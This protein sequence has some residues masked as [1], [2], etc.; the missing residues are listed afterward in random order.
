M[1]RW[2]LISD[3]YINEIFS[4]PINRYE[5]YTKD[6]NISPLSVESLE[7]FE[8]ASRKILV[9]PLYMN[10]HF[11]LL[12]S[13]ISDLFNSSSCIIKD[14]ICALL[15][16]GRI[17]H[18]QISW[19]FDNLAVLVFTDDQM[20]IVSVTLRKMVYIISEIF[21][22]T[23]RS[24]LLHNCP[25]K[26]ISD[27]D[28]EI[29]ACYFGLINCFL[30]TEIGFLFC[31]P[32]HGSLSDT[33]LYLLIPSFLIINQPILLKKFSREFIHTIFI[34][35]E[36]YPCLLIETGIKISESFLL[37]QPNVLFQHL[38]PDMLLL[39]EELIPRVPHLGLQIIREFILKLQPNNNASLVRILGPV[40]SIFALNGD[41]H[42]EEILHL[43][44]PLMDADCYLVRNLGLSTLTDILGLKCSRNSKSTNSYIFDLNY[45]L[46]DNL[47][48]HILDLNAFVRTRC[49]SLITSLWE[50]DSIPLNKQSYFL[51][52]LVGRIFDTSVLVRKQTFFALTSILQK[53]PFNS[54]VLNFQ[55][56]HLT[57]EREL[58]ILQS[59][60]SNF[61]D[62]FFQ[63]EIIDSVLNADIEDFLQ[64]NDD[65]SII[66]C[67]PQEEKCLYDKLISEVSIGYVGDCIATFDWFKRYKPKHFVFQNSSVDVTPVI[68]GLSIHDLLTLSTIIRN[69]K[70]L[71]CCKENI[72]QRELQIQKVNFL[73]S[74][75]GFIDLLY[76]CLPNALKTLQ[77]N[78]SSD[79]LSSLLFLIEYIKY[80]LPDY[81]TCINPIMSLIWSHHVAHRE[82]AIKTFIEYFDLSFNNGYSI[83]SQ[84][85]PMIQSVSD[86][87][88]SNISYMEYYSIER[89]LSSLAQQR[90]FPSDLFS[91]LLQFST[92]SHNFVCS[93]F[94]ANILM[95][96]CMIAR[97]FDL[98]LHDDFELIASTCFTKNLMNLEVAR[99]GCSA[100]NIMGTRQNLS[101][102]QFP[103]L[104]ISHPI[105]KS[106]QLLI[107]SKLCDPE[108]DWSS[109]MFDSLLL[110]LKLS[111]AP[112][113]FFKNCISNCTTIINIIFDERR[114]LVAISRVFMLIGRVAQ[115]FILLMENKFSAPDY[116]SFYSSSN[117]PTNYANELNHVN[118]DQSYSFF[119]SDPD[120]NTDGIGSK[121]IFSRYT[122]L[123]THV[124]QNSIYVDFSKIFKHKSNILISFVLQLQCSAIFALSQLMMLSIQFCEISIGLIVSLMTKHNCQYIRKSCIFVI[125]DLIMR[126]PNTLQPWIPYV[127]RILRDSSALVRKQALLVLSHLILIDIVKI[128]GFIAEIA[129][130]IED[131]NS[132]I[133]EIAMSFFSSISKDGNRLY[134]AL[135]DII[136]HILDQNNNQ[137]EVCSIKNILHFIFSYIKKEK[138]VDKLIEKL[139]NRFKSAQNNKQREL[140][141]F[142]IS[143]LPHSERTLIYLISQYSILRSVI[144]NENTRSHFLRISHGIHK[145]IK[146]IPEMVDL[147]SEFDGLLHNTEI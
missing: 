34:C 43:I 118:F 124:L 130:L 40:L 105:F 109:F 37:L 120:I 65:I 49:I 127:F 143:L 55:P 99:L 92:Q 5:L 132:A 87:I 108:V 86:K 141:A 104:K 52:M 116:Q 44:I 145:H 69:N 23:F 83:I 76:L 1:F 123:L 17:L 107:S 58:S 63:F 45:I 146:K 12:I 64:S 73:K 61:Y 25:E 111:R 57:L 100:L 56:F 15:L 103:R 90:K 133:G 53:N 106:I 121:F 2:D 89:I 70:E 98:N 88:Y 7:I 84:Y 30:S 11:E 67:D 8:A 18:D 101:S 131:E 6:R 27:T 41:F 21:L 74:A 129:Y 125:S 48:D 147:L 75:I 36:K 66:N 68:L 93:N 112:L 35:L 71:E 24:C 110:S 113:M 31:S 19:M 128:Q 94:V 10:D 140:I 135:P 42:V 81:L 54:E 114:K 122:K 91:V 59:I 26:N 51:E 46:F 137:L 38:Q 134:N 62:R 20:S 138:Q 22:K 33:I 50:S 144:Q 28:V 13:T 136:S 96:T 9:S 126:Y 119:A 72:I 97:E 60:E 4:F 29:F 115:L 16:S 47:S 14:F 39:L 32:T 139:I 3:R 85:T 80:K 77:S 79:V 82:Y 78:L 117:I 95:I 142:S 102:I